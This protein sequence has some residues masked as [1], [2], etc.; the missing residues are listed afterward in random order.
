MKKWFKRLKNEK[1]MTLVELLAVVVIL[2]IVAAIAVPSIGKVI[3]NSKKDAHVS[4]ALLIIDA[5][6]LGIISGE[7][8]DT[9]QKAGSDGE[10]LVSTIVGKDLLDT[11][12]KDPDNNTTTA[13]YGATSYVKYDEGAN[14]YSIYLDGTKR[15]V[16]KSDNP[17]SEVSLNTNGRNQ[18]HEPAE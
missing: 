10:F 7:L 14:E 2:G 8:T 3:D 11:N 17:A 16:G 13:G 12:P 4:N 5:A 6:K 9:D 1:G 15:D 18:I